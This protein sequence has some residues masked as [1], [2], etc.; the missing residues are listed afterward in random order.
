MGIWDGIIL[1]EAKE[2]KIIKCQGT[3][4]EIGKQYG[5]ACREDFHRIVDS[6]Y[7]NM[8]QHYQ[9]SKEQIIADVNKFLPLVGL[10]LTRRVSESVTMKLYSFK[11]LITSLIFPRDAICPR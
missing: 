11:M 2:F 1:K 9:I 7:T 8:Q 6:Y 10:V 5:D 4:Y 3:D